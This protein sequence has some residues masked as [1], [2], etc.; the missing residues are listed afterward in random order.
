MIKYKLVY[1]IF[2]RHHI[3]YFATKQ[4][5]ET[6]AIKDGIVIKHKP[7]RVELAY[8]HTASRKGYIRKGGEWDEVYAGKFGEGIIRHKQNATF[9]SPHNSKN[10][11]YVEYYIESK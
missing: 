1:T 9:G 4:E 6:F 3:H 11:H 7:R 5:A 8:H 2:G 10:Y